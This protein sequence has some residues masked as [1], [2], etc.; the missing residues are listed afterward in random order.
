MIRISY[1]KVAQTSYRWRLDDGSE[2][3][4]TSFASQDSSA[5]I[6]YPTNLRLRFTITNTGETT[7]NNYTLEYSP[8]ANGCY[9]WNAVPVTP[10]T[11]PFNMFNTANFTNGANSTNVSSGPGVMTPDPSGF[12]FTAGKLLSTA[13]SA[14]ITLSTAQFTEIEYSIQPNSNA[15]QSQYCF[16]VTNAG[17]ALDDYNN[18]Y[19]MLNIQYLP[20]APTVSAP[21]NSA[22]GVSRLPVF[23]MRSSDN[24]NDY[25]QYVVETCP[26]NSFPCASG[27][28]T[29]NETSAC[30]SQQ[31]VQSGTA[32]SGYADINQSAMAYCQTPTSDI[33]AP[34]T[35]YYM[36]AKAIDP[37]GSNTYSPYSS[38]ISFTTGTLEINIT[39][40]TN[41]TGGTKIGG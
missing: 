18:N 32:F 27:G 11:E 20:S 9:N 41:I 39:G 16:R 37:G 29:Y 10:T 30:W 1:T 23:Q 34:N 17:T 7:S 38:V 15:A 35:T 31:D 14:T 28:H 33:L 40:S 2:T 4:G 12:S 6:T 22:T 13:N 21:T 25:L 24:N 8:Y 26:A 19:P 5:S 36:R 3:T